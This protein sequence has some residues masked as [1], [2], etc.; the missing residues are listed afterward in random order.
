MLRPRDL[1]Q[2]DPLTAKE[3]VSF[4]FGAVVCFTGVIIVLQ[5]VFRL[6]FG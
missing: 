6:F 3:W 4:S 5:L 2:P 1:T